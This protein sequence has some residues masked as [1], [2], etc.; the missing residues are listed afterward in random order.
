VFIQNQITL[1]FSQPILVLK[2]T[3]LNFNV[4]LNVAFGMEFQK[5]EFVN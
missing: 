1:G 5:F 2:V 4:N 3:P